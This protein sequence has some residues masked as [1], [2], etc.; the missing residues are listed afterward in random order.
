MP[1]QVLEMFLNGKSGKNK[2]TNLKIANALSINSI[3][4]WAAI[5]LKIQPIKLKFNE[6]PWCSIDMCFQYNYPQSKLV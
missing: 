4:P 3:K 1:T 2:T 5:T 6:L